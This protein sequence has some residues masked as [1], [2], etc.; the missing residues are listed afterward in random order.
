MSPSD[1]TFTFYS[2]LGGTSLN[3]RNRKCD[4]YF[5]FTLCDCYKSH[6]NSENYNYTIYE[7]PIEYN[8][9]NITKNE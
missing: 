4:F 5:E 2:I 6:A 8:N 9:N 3:I 7:H 1:V